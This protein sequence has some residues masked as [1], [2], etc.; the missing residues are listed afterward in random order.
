M[1]SNWIQLCQAVLGASA[2]S[3]YGPVPVNTQ[4]AVHAAQAYNPGATPVV[5]DVFIVPTSG[6][7]ADATHVDRVQVSAGAAQPVAGLI[8]QKLTPGMSLFA[9]GT[10]V[11]LTVSGIAVG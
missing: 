3:V 2:A 9:V 6:T 5:V 1:A 10:G 4:I 11:T 8:N 7:A